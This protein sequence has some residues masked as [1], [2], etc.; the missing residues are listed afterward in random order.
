MRP[1]GT[2]EKEKT[3]PTIKNADDTTK[4]NDDGSGEREIKK[5]EIKSKERRT[6][7][8]IMGQTCGK[9]NGRVIKDATIWEYHPSISSS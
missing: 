6:G 4:R 9:R 7:V 3:L 5:W 8:E 2:R 1:K